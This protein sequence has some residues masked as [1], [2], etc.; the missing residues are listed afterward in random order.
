MEQS[1]Q[2]VRLLSMFP[3]SAPFSLTAALMLAGCVH[4]P[5]LARPAQLTEA[6][7]LASTASLTAQPGVWPTENWWLGFGDPGLSA[8][9]DEALQGSPDLRNAAARVAAADAMAE[10]AGAALRPSVSLDASAGLNQQ[11]RS[12][13]FPPQFIPGGL[14]DTGR[15]ALGASFNPDL[16]GKN[17]A[18]LAAATSEAEAA[19]VDA[20][21]SRLMLT[22]AI[23]AAWA[24]LARLYGERD[25]VAAARQVRQETASLTDRRYRAGIEARGPL[26]QAQA[27]VP[28]TD[29]ELG[30]LDEAI[31]ISRHRLAALAGAGPDRGLAIIRPQMVPQGEGLPGDAG[32]EL[33]ARRPDLV[34]ARLHA[35]AAAA[36]IKAARADFY[37][38]I[39]LSG[40]I[41]GQSLG[42]GN[43][44][45]ST[46][47][48][49]NGSAA[50]SLPV[51]DGGRIAA[52][53][54]G[55][56]ADYEGAVAR[57]DATLIAALRDVADAVT[58]RHMA[59]AAI[60]NQ[61]RAVDFSAD[62]AR[63]ARARW[64]GGLST[65]LPVLIAQDTLFAHQRVLANLEARRLGL[66][67]ALIR[68]LGG[69][70][71]S[72][73]PAKGE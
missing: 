27:R 43:L 20:A 69:G 55:A 36:R 57:Y 66:E 53:Y 7:A 37:P 51:F 22:T 46:A 17:R 38:N 61:Q 32:I 63:A 19:R 9:I 49:A 58:A 21:Q 59:E 24:E 41:G 33:V 68:A 42:L 6:A 29:A 30:G 65:Q 8:L 73:P 15:I 39:A 44:F 25:S 16:W 71:R 4:V 3:T 72:A 50:F 13:G 11:S 48:I 52:H 56:S 62:A 70:Y 28:A 2:L 35:A 34:S 12:V 40:F 23:G 67:I 5:D 47:R 14:K 64:L 54:R 26:S 31:A 45:G 1:Y 10:Q 60:A 18:L